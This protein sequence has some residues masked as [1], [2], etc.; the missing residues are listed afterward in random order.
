[1]ITDDTGTQGLSGIEI[2]ASGEY[3]YDNEDNVKEYATEAGLNAAIGIYETIDI[4]LYLPYQWI[5]TRNTVSD[6]FEHG[7]GDMSCEFKWLFINKGPFSFALKPG[8]IIPT[9]DE[10]KELGTGKTGYSTFFISSF[11]K[12]PLALHFNAGYIRNNNDAGDFENIWHISM[13][14]EYALTESFSVVANIGCDRNPSKDDNTVPAYLLGG[15]VFTLNE[16]LDIDAGLKWGFT[17]PETDIS[18]LAGLTMHFQ[19]M[20]N[21]SNENG[22]IKGD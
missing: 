22:V 18:I 15:F 3:G 14:G 2:E 11:D 16:L 20:N 8:L 6:S 19:A 17:K 21:E 4:V 10:S 12:N 5:K 7:L 1:M 13:A 9:G